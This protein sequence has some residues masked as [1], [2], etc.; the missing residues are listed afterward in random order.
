MVLQVVDDC[1]CC[2]VVYVY[3]GG[4]VCLGDVGMIVD[5]LEYGD[6]FLCQFQFGESVGEMLIDCVVCQLD[7]EVD[8]I[9]DF[10]DVVGVV[11][12]WGCCCD[13]IFYV[14]YCI[15]FVFVVEVYF[16]GFV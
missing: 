10:V 15:L 3:V 11:F 2:C 5:Q 8:D 4:E 7:M 13:L 16:G 9:V 14:G 1:Y 6:L 12:G